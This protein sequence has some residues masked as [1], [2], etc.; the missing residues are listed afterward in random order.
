MSMTTIPLRLPEDLKTLATEQAEAMGVSLNQYVGMTL[1]IRVGAQAEAEAF[2]A[3]RGA[4][5]SRERALAALARIGG[6]DEPTDED[7]INL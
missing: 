1:A 4:C 2:F 7:R 3:R 5:G 6:A